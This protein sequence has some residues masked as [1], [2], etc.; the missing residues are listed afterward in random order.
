MAI[1]KDVL[2]TLARQ[3]ACKRTLEEVKHI[4]GV[5]PQDVRNVLLEKL[6]KERFV[7]KM[8][9]NFERQFEVSARSGRHSVYVYSAAVGNRPRVVELCALARALV[10]V[11][12]PI[13]DVD[14]MTYRLLAQW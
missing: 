9:E 2:L 8:M 11:C 4:E 6:E 3:N 14:T 7:E 1:N 12:D 13:I 10:K 5:I